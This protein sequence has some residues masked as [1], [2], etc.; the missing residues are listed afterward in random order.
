MAHITLPEGLPG[1]R[2]LLTYS[3]ETA[4]PMAELTQTLMRGPGTLTFAEREMVAAVVS[5][6]NACHYC[7]SAHE[8]IAAAHL[9]GAPDDYALVEQVQRDPESAPISPKMKALLAIA[10][11]IQQDGKLVTTADVERAR[12]EGATDKEVHDVVLIAAA[13]CMFNRYVDGLG[14]WQP[15]DPPFYREA[16]RLTAERGYTNREPYQPLRP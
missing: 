16:G 2:G 6:R 7:R 4:G 1:I 15:D 3:P 13:F 14:T 11:K 9:G 10:V 5:S 8:A 12:A